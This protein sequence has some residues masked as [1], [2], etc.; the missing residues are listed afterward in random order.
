METIILPIKLSNSYEGLAES[1]GLVSFEKDTVRLQFQTKDS[2][3]G[4]LKSDL[5]DV[6]IPLK[7]IQEIGYKKSLLDN[8][9]TIK[10]DDL[11]LIRELPDS[12]NSEISLSVARANIEDA[13]DLVRAIKLDISEKEYNE[14]MSSST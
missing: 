6:D 14:A 1:K 3:F 13:I 10:V 8:K 7:N 12:D 9:L 5:K 11:R 2:I 4:V